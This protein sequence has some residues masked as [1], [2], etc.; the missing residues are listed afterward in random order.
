MRKYPPEAYDARGLLKMDA[1]PMTEPLDITRKLELLAN[2]QPGEQMPPELETNR[3]FRESLSSRLNN[4]EIDAK[5]VISQRVHPE[6][7]PE[8]WGSPF[9][10]DTRNWK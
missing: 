2:L 10:M 4:M 6:T 3:W 5:I 8:P 7:P 9:A 1:K